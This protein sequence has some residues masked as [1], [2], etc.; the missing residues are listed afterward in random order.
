MSLTDNDENCSHLQ[1][2]YAFTK[3]A[4]CRR[5]ISGGERKMMES[6]GEIIMKI[7]RTCPPFL[8]ATHLSNPFQLMKKYH[9][10][11]L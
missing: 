5:R 11:K 7:L 1:S 8:L 10:L 9:Y 4:V 2:I 6:L 3:A